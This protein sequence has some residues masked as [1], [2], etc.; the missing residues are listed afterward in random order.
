MA[1][2]TIHPHGFTSLGKIPDGLV[3]IGRCD[4]DYAFGVYVELYSSEKWT[5]QPSFPAD[6]SFCYYSTAT[7]ENVL[8]VFGQ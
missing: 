4:F 2:S 3:A 8:Y 7:Y 6:E 1:V 5:V